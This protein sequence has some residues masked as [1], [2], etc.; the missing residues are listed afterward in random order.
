MPETRYSFGEKIGS[1]NFGNVRLAVHRFSG[2]ER[3][4]KT[5]HCE[6]RENPDGRLSV[7]MTLREVNM[8]AQLDH[9]HILRIYESFR[10]KNDVH[11]VTDICSGGDLFDIVRQ[12]AI[13]GE[14]C[15]EPL[16]IRIFTQ[17]LQAIAHCHYR[18][19]M[20]K[21]LKFENIM[22]RKRLTRAS[23]PEEAH[24]VVI[25]MGL[26][27]FFGEQHNCSNRSSAACGTLV[28]MAPEVLAHDFTCKCDIWS[29]GCL[30]FAMIN[31]QPR[32]TKCP[33]GK[34]TIDQF[35]F[36]VE[37]TADDPLGVHD[38]MAKHC[39]GPDFR[40]LDSV[41]Q[42][43]ISVVRAMLSYEERDRPGAV[44]C[45]RLPWFRDASD[46]SLHRL[47][48][49][50]VQIVVERSKRELR[51]FS[52]MLI[53][54][55][56]SQLPSSKL[57]AFEEQFKAIDVQGKGHISH[58]EMVQ[59]L[60]QLRVPRQE[61]E[62]VTDAMDL[63]RTGCISWSEFVTALL[64]TSEDLLMEGLACFIPQLA[65][66]DGTVSVEELEKATR[67]S[68][69]VAFP[70]CAAEIML[71]EIGHVG[72]GKLN[73]ND[74]KRLIFGRETCRIGGKR[75]VTPIRRIPSSASSARRQLP[76]TPIAPRFTGPR[77]CER[78][79]H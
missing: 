67:K 49:A 40:Q 72:D 59:T 28:T 64:P 65:N 43:A 36:A 8:L 20:H 11:I 39:Q 45:L 50:Q 52:D 57:A 44:A 71:N 38:L 6:D 79:Q 41:S 31:S 60:H 29:V 13:D 12:N 2:F 70:K 74:I 4:V 73:I 1:G 3:V 66:D 21:D 53:A 24:I 19:V 17:V 69:D 9:P 10:E 54:R 14:S 27:E 26:S 61:A 62:R 34:V 56:A 23:S 55:A 5:V 7:D 33:N 76:T 30:I 48:L 42:N 51:T 46:R 15:P 32:R 22:L 78:S 25:D 75:L 63:S 35:P 47:S 77:T 37:P 18:G 58:I 16:A 68:C